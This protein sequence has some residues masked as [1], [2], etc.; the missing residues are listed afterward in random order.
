VDSDHFKRKAETWAQRARDVADITVRAEYE[1]LAG[2][3]ADLAWR[4][5]DTGALQRQE[6]RRR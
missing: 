3:Y 1:R 5:T 2:Y 4:L 6:P